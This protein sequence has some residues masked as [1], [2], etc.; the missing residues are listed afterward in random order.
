[1]SRAEEKLPLAVRTVGGM[2]VLGIGVNV[3]G[4]VVVGAVIS[5]MN[6]RAS[7]HQFAVLLTVT[8]ATVAFSLITGVVAATL[9]QG[10]TLRWLRDS[11]TPSPADARRALRMPRDLAVIAV[12]LWVLG[13]AAIAVA[14]AAVGEDA[15]TV[16]GICGGIVLAALASAGLTYLLTS[17]LWPGSPS[18]PARPGRC[19]SSASG[20]GCC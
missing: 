20:G 3:V 2:A 9:V 12:V 8:A 17:R 18:P 1:V 14:A 4:V 7:R 5:A 13:G 19:R 11:T 10:R 16:S 6:A 15:P